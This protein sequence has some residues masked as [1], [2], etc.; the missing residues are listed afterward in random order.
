MD[1]GTTPEL[2]D[3]HLL[4]EEEGDFVEQSYVHTSPDPKALTKKA[5]SRQLRPNVEEKPRVR[6]NAR[7]IPA[8]DDPLAPPSLHEKSPFVVF[9]DPED[10][11][12]ESDTRRFATADLPPMDPGAFEPTMDRSNTVELH[13]E[14]ASYIEKFDD[15]DASTAEQEPLIDR[16]STAALHNELDAV[17]N[18][19]GAEDS[20]ETEKK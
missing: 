15:S 3:G 10:S 8:W 20:T 19:L 1:M 16:R 18:D 2:Q 14:L 11:S 13:N 12:S 5:A 9:V 17:I 4:V 6:R 7:S